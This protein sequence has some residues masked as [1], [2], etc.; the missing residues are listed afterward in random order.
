MNIQKEAELEKLALIKAK[1][2]LLSNLANMPPGS[3]RID[4][5]G[6]TTYKLIDAI[7]PVDLFKNL[8]WIAAFCVWI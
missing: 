1:N 7:P 6:R 3:L 8:N 5:N 4:K 2:R